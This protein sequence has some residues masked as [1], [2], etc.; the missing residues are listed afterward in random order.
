MDFLILTDFYH[1]I[2]LMLFHDK[3]SQKDDMNVRID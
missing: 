2:G 3:S 1:L